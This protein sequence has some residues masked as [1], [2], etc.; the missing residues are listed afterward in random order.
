MPSIPIH[1]P[2][3]RDAQGLRLVFESGRIGSR[4]PSLEDVAS[5][6][7]DI[8][9]HIQHHSELH[10]FRHWQRTQR[11]PSF[12][13]SPI[14][15]KN[16]GMPHRVRRGPGDYKNNEYSS[17]FGFERSGADGRESQKTNR[18]ACPALQSGI[19]F[20]YNRSGL[21]AVMARRP[22]RLDGSLPQGC[23]GLPHHVFRFY[24]IRYIQGCG[25]N[26]ISQP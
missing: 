9:R 23:T 3:R 12:G 18:A 4:P 7:D 13:S 17:E 2:V 20:P 14:G 26:S 5:A 8:V 10:Q 25:K 11:M 15:P 22:S 6:A 19:S 21:S 1:M 16:G 24:C